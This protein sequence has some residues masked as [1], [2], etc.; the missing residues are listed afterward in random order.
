MPTRQGDLSLLQHPVAQQLLQSTDRA[1]FAY[2][3]RDGTPRV[4][5]IGFLWNGT[6]IVLATATDAPKLK[7]LHDGAKVALTIDTTSFPPRVLFIR[8]T[9]RTDVVDGLAPEYV[10]MAQRSMDEQASKTFL[11]QSAALYPRMARIFI[12][13]EWVGLHDFETS[14][15]SAVE[16]AM[17]RNRVA[18]EKSASGT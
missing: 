4:V 17:E 12:R 14:F 2:T 1:S 11:E 16:R 3:W 15:P 13:P 8:G 6:E 10:T 5:P 18:A 7:A 9:V